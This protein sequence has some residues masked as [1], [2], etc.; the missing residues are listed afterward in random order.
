MDLSTL[1]NVINAVAVSAGVIFAAVQVHLYREQQR[2]DAM[3]ALVRSY[4][5]PAFTGA[6]RRVNTLPDGA[7]RQRIRELLGPDGED[8]V[9]LLGLTWESLGL[10]LFRRE[11]TLDVMDDFFSGAIEISWR[12][13]HVFVEED[14][15][16]TK[17]DT[18]W[19]WFQW[20]AERM[21]SREKDT[22]PVPAHIAHRSWR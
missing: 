21:K 13:L 10:L 20:L 14:R 8:S 9:F 4:Q 17:R 19:E 7:G 6:L 3:L 2:R 22:P 15:L 16:S 1:A 12:K 18:A 5:S 11:V